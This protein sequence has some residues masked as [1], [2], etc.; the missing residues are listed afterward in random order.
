M[1]E[2]LE[3][4]KERKEDRVSHALSILTMS[5]EVFESDEDKRHL[6]SIAA[7]NLDDP[8]VS[9]K[10]IEIL[11]NKKISFKIKDQIIIITKNN[12]YVNLLGLTDLP[13][14]KSNV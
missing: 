10:W 2:L 6:L 9:K 3:T 1:E 7:R 14:N 12:G 4:I 13:E 8:K 5:K 11:K